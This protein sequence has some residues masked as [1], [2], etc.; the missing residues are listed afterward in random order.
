MF[1]SVTIREYDR[2][3]GEFITS[4]SLFDSNTI[5]MGSTSD[6]KVFDFLVNGVSGVSSISISL[7]Y[8]DNVE[9]S[10]PDAVVVNGVADKGNFGIDWSGDF[11]PNKDVEKFFSATD[12]YL[13]IPMRS[14]GMSDYV[15]L[16]VYP[17]TFKKKNGEIKY[18][19]RFLYDTQVSSSSSSS[20]IY[21]SSSSSSS[22]FS[23][24]SSS[25]CSCSSSCSSSS[26]SLSSS[27]CS[28]S[29]CSC[30]SSSCSCSSCSCSSCSCSS[31]SCSSSNCYSSSS[32]SSSCSCS[33]SSSN[34][35]S[36]S[37]CS[38]S[39]SSSSCSS[40]SSSSSSTI[41]YLYDKIV[42]SDAQT[43]DFFGYSSAIDGSYAIC[44]AIGEDTGATS[45]GA[46][47]VF[48]RNISGDWDSGTKIQSSSIQASALFGNS[49]SISGDYAIVGAFMEDSGSTDSG[50]AY[51]F[52]RTGENTWSSGA[53]IL[54]TFSSTQYYFGCSVS[55]SGDY[56]VVGAYGEQISSVR[57][58]AIYIF[59]RTDVNTWGS[60]TRIPC[61]HLIGDTNFGYSVAISG[62]YMVVGSKTE[63]VVRTYHRTGS[64]IWSSGSDLVALDAS[65][66]DNFGYSVAIS[67]D[68][69]IVGATGN[70]GGAGAAYIFHRTGINTW[71]A[72]TKIVAYDRHYN[73]NFGLSV[74]ISGDY[75]IIAAKHSAVSGSLST[76]IFRRIGTNSWEENSKIISSNALTG[77]FSDHLISLSGD[78]G[79]VGAPNDDDSA[80]DAG[81]A[82]IY[83]FTN[84]G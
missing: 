69:V 14:L 22:S 41:Y 18:K 17:G 36:S 59:N 6:T 12:V 58:G 25:S 7:Y 30:S 46:A 68:Y 81:A 78:Y 61:P 70:Y 31:S 4:G 54:G 83:D 19:I 38:S 32:S 72:G 8:T 49:I 1:P 60:V 77:N 73:D 84:I 82:Y 2:T 43:N 5:V 40:S 28:C 20:G 55:I 16:N 3:T 79:I 23:S 63:Q 52:H 11:V 26:S 45:A 50:A 34:S 33:C 13:E 71:D 66:G 56:A 53:R 21:P 62:D 67:G 64:N 10:P 42:A 80:S 76:Y 24:S 35:F 48:F 51:I 27:S 15:Y 9:V 65:G 74:A 75:A 29:S 47:Y 44:G 57:A 39:C 37:S